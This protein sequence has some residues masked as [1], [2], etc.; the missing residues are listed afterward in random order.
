[1]GVF[2]CDGRYN[3]LLKDIR[4]ELDKWYKREGRPFD[5]KLLS[6]DI[7]VSMVVA[8][9]SDNRD[10]VEGR[11]ELMHLHTAAR[12]SGGSSRGSSPTQSI[13]GQHPGPP[14]EPPK[15]GPQQR[16]S[17]SPRQPGKR[18]CYPHD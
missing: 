3:K 5:V 17:R 10:W 7:Q 6:H 2:L 4:S 9:G 14:E 13:V 1:M 16:S 12:T 11:T 8:Q 15:P 18:V